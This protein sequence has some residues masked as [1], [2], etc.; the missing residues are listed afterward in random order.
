MNQPSCI[1]LFEVVSY[2]LLRFLRRLARL[3]CNH[4]SYAPQPH[5]PRLRQRAPERGPIE[6]IKIVRSED[7]GDPEVDF[8]DVRGGNLGYYEGDPREGTYPGE[9]EVEC[10]EV[11]AV[12]YRREKIRAV[13][14]RENEAR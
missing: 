14:F 6:P 3:G 12:G 8:F 10:P 13:C 5:E 9:D 1:N 7:I 2:T 4:E 11:C